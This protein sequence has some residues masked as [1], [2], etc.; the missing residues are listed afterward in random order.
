MTEEE[1]ISYDAVGLADEI[2]K[3]R[4]SPHEVLD[5]AMTR[6][7]RINPAINSICIKLYDQAKQQLEISDPSAPLYGV[8]FLIKDLRAAYAGVPTTAGSRF[9][10][11]TPAADS[12]V[13][14]RYK[15]AGLIIFGKTNVPEMGMSIDTR[16]RLFG[17]THNPWA[18]DRTAG[19]SSG[20]SAASV[21]ARLV[22]A[23]HASDGAG[24]IRVPSS[25]CGVFGLK[26]SRGRVTYSPDGEELA[27]MSVQHAVTRSVR[28]SAALLDITCP[29]AAGDPSFAPAA[30]GGYLNYLATEFRSLRVAVATNA[31]TSASVEL[32]CKTAALDAG[33]L[34]EALGHTVEA[35]ILDVNWYGGLGDAVQTLLAAGFYSNARQKAILDTKLLD[36][37]EFYPAVFQWL[38]L[39]ETISAADY[40][41]ALKVVHA[42]ARKMANF[43]QTYDVLITPSLTEIPRSIAAFDYDRAWEGNFLESEFWRVAAFLPAFNASGQPC[44]S[45]P[46]FQT[47][48]GLPIGVQIV[49][50]F[51]E[52]HVLL[53]LAAELERIHPWAGRVPPL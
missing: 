20:G 47:A 45:I 50:R 11:S 14:Q 39:G 21:A 22:P 1:Y 16:N 31:F 25:C 18:L 15:Q 48:D 4:V 7:D 10:T 35:V 51:G 49:G 29:P 13:T 41:Q 19:G 2:R 28:D 53:K 26:V 40:Y 17:Q 52:E 36:A 37:S 27:G 32:V 46:L 6:S 8:P 43:H 5:I 23:A 42:F 30:P 33:R 9:L 44:A 3:E 12:V 24:S 34:C 38:K